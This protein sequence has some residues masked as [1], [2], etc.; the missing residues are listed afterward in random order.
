I[1]FS[2]DP[3]PLDP[4]TAYAAVDLHRLDRRA[5][6]LLRTHD[7]GRT[8]DVITGGLPRDEITSVVRS[9]PRAQGLLFAGTDRAVY[10]SFDDGDWWQELSLGL[11]STWMRDLLPHADDLIVATQGRG[12]WVLDDVTSL[13]EA[14][15]AARHDIHLFTPAVAT[16]LRPSES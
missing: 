1:V 15:E 10:V 6:L 3:S 8:W 12:L 9:D 2:I 7:A 13:R 4:A 11:P 5:P 16:R 14:R